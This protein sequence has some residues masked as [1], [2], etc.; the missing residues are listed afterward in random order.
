LDLVD[1][2]GL[3]ERNPWDCIE[4]F[5]FWSC[6]F[7]GGVARCLA[8]IPTVTLLIPAQPAVIPEVIPEVT[9]EARAIRGPCPT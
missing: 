3:S 2:F 6:S 9:P 7:W 8:N 5:P 4:P 1:L